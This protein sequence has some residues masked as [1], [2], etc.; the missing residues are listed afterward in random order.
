MFTSIISL[1]CF[2]SL[3]AFCTVLTETIYR[4][5]DVY[6]AIANCLWT[7]CCLAMLM[8]VVQE[9]ASKKIYVDNSIHDLCSIASLCTAGYCLIGI[10]LLN[11]HLFQCFQ[12]FSSQD[13]ESYFLLNIVLWISLIF[14]DYLKV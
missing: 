3:C 12:L 1:T 2:L 5:S 14:P 9:F 10:C 6:L 7:V 8:E 4:L 11:S 13:I